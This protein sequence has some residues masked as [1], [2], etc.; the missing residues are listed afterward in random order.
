MYTRHL[1]RT[2]I[3][4]V[5]FGPLAA[6]QP[7]QKLRGML[8][9]I[10]NSGEFAGRGGGAG[11]GGRGGGGGARWI[12][13][14]Q[15]Y[16]MVEQGQIVRYDTATGAH[17]VLVS[18]E[19][20]ISDYQWSSDGRKLLAL[21]NPHRVLIRKTAGEY[22]VLDPKGGAPR[23]LAG[24]QGSDLLFAKFSPDGSRV[25]YVRDTNV[26]VEDLAGGA[27]RQLTS[28]GTNM[29]LNGVSDWVYDEEFRLNDGIRWSPDSQSI[30]YWQFDQHDVPVYALVNYTDQLYPTIFQYPYPKAGQTNAAVRVGV[31]SAKGG[32]TRWIKVPGD[33][34][35]IYIPRMEWTPQGEV[36]L[37]NLNRLQNTNDVLLGNPETGDV[38]RMFRDQD[39]AWVE[40]NDRMH[41]V[42]GG[43]RL[44]WTCEKDGWR[45]AYTVG[46]DGDMRLITTAPGDVISI[47]AVDT[48]GG[49][50]YYIASPDEPTRRYLYR[51]RLNGSGK[52]ER[53]T[54]ANSPGTHNY[55][56]APNARWAFHTY[57]RFNQ[58]ATT[59]LVKLPAH[60]TV[61]VVADNQELKQKVAELLGDRTEFVTVDAGDGVTIDGWVMKPRNFDASKKY[62]IV[63]YV[64]G[65]PAGANA[66]DNFSGNR[67]L[68]H[69]ALADEGYLV[70][71]FDNSGTPSPKGRAWRKVIYGSVGVLASKQQA[72][73][74]RSLAASRPW[75]D[76]TRVAVWGWSGG[77]SMTDNLMF[78][79]PDL[80]KVGVAVAAVPD[81]TLYDSIYQE[82]YMGLPAGNAKGYHDG[83]PI[84]FAEGL[85]GKLLI[86]HG[87]GDDNVHFQGD[88][89]LINRLVEL[90]KP[91]D[92]ME[93]PNRTHGITEGRGTQLHVYTLIAR[94]LEEHLP[95]GAR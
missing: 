16:A 18:T 23:K 63:V 49:W 57:A 29:I 48:A 83:S 15:A 22:W 37:E 89:R 59:D 52:P 9:R 75:V 39:A 11:R 66:V 74:L 45:H 77:G 82:R 10:F 30:A 69:A 34:R 56:I 4:A 32:P 70:A 40:V 25:A 8:Q 46:R 38:R 94:Y 55:D 95:A 51:T 73:A 90:G 65:E 13:D 28:D 86:V 17:S 87:T 71:T 72:A 1:N 2:L 62:P 20:A 53:L 92:F 61:R 54:P 78:R 19:H 81:Q 3:L 76:L 24:G 91:F 14:G 6:A 80:Y 79:S 35:N 68:F 31:V 47:A 88:Q 42:D 60:E 50:L 41:W 44:L 27:I 21:T 5:R 64:Y 85:R 7:S 12:E 93:Y 58:P 33:P 26:Y 67:E 84:S 43:N 36:I